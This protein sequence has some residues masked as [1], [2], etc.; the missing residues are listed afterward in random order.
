MPN[1]GFGQQVTTAQSVNAITNKITSRYMD[2]I[3]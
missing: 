3:L 1:Q 2:D